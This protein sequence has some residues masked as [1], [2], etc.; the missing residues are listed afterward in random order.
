MIIFLFADLVTQDSLSML[1]Q[2]AEIVIDENT[3]LHEQLMG[4][5]EDKLANDTEGQRSVA[6]VYPNCSHTHL[7]LGALNNISSIEP[8]SC[9]T[10]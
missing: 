5:I 8:H 10:S 2:K 1:K 9:L 4:D 3:R 7:E 6:E